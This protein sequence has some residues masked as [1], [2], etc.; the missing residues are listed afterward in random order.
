M[1]ENTTRKTLPPDETALFCEQIAMVL[2][3]GIPLGDGMETLA[4]SYADSRYG[5]RFDGM[6]AALER[7]G[8]FSEALED[9]GIFPNYLIAMTRIG[10]RSG[11][12]D[13]V[14]A[15]LANY[16]QWEADI[17]ISVKNAILYPTVL[18]M[19]LAVVFPAPCKGVKPPMS[20]TPGGV[21][22]E[23]L[24]RIDTGGVASLNHRLISVT[25]SGV[26][27]RVSFA[28]R[29]NKPLPRRCANRE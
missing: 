3:A 5:A 29:T 26:I 13:E 15:S 27:I 20:H 7:R 19:M 18:V 21:L 9:A 11:K 22:G 25:P 23:S 6:R 17:R 4:R 8:T 1:Q 14:M 24:K 28:D 2:K 10:E 12:L 16:Y